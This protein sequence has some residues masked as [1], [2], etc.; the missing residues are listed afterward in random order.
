MWLVCDEKLQG[1]W[2]QLFAELRAEMA[3]WANPTGQLRAKDGDGEDE[4]ASLEVAEAGRLWLL[5]RSAR[6]DRLWRRG[7]YHVNACMQSLGWCGTWRSPPCLSAL[8]Q[9]P[10]KSGPQTVPYDS[11]SR[12]RR[13]PFSMH[14]LGKPANALCRR[15]S[16]TAT[17]AS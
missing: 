4:I 16:C 15:E 1:S 13:V 5:I 8:M 12:G 3:K 10:G 7:A 9:G 14:G 17:H 2:R 11:A 6:D